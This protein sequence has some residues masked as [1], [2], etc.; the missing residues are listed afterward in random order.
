[1]TPLTNLNV[2]D[3]TPLISPAT[4]KAELP[5][6]RE[7]EA[8]V[9]KS[10]DELVAVIE[11]RSKKMVV[12]VG[13]C[14]IHDTTAAAEYSDKLAK[15]ALQYQDKMLVIMRAYFEKP[16]TTV[17]WKGGIYDPNMDGS[18]DLSGGLRLARKV[19]LEITSKG[20]PVATEFLD[21]IVPQF[22]D[23][24]VTEAS[25]GART[26]ESQTHRQ[27][28]SGLSMPVGFKNSTDGSVQVAI[29]AMRSAESGH[30]FIGIDNDGRLAN[31]QTRGNAFGHVVLRGGNGHTNFD[32]ETLLHVGE[33]LANAGLNRG[34]L[35]DCSH[36]NSHKKHEKQEVAWSA[37][38]AEFLKGDTGVIGMMLESNLLEGNQS[39]PANLQGFDQS[40]LRYGVSVTDACIGWDQTERMLREAYE[41][42]G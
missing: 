24:L 29:D 25:I 21:P 4:L 13:P 1:M 14:S 36:A 5:A 30:S 15:C 38:L 3:F 37:V 20:L 23:D 41:L 9:R 8:T 10:R 19:M 39:L 16:R 42:L 6:T 11:G 17:G 34:I 40:L 12:V 2:S 33:K 35:V 26:T 22:L 31:V 27:M 32:R 18:N 7:S 28:A